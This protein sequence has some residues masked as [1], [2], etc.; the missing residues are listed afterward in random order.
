[1]NIAEIKT[2]DIANGEG[3]RTSVLFQVAATIAPIALTK[4][5]GI[6]NMANHGTRTR[7]ISF[8]LPPHLRG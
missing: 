3:V 6:L 1:M 5:P 2:N 8:Y 4:S 7:K